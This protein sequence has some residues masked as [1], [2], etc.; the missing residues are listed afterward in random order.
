[1]GRRV[2]EGL[3]SDPVR[4]ATAKGRKRQVQ[5]CDFRTRPRCRGLRNGC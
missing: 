5:H 2:G 4:Q 1:M 3:A